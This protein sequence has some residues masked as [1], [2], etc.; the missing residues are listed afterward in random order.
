[1][2]MPVIVPSTTTRDQAIT[3]VIESVALEQT[4]LSH[5]LN[6][7]G[8]KL[9]AVIAMPGVTSAELLDVNKSVQNMVSSI[10]ML[11]TVLQMKLDIFSC[12]ICPNG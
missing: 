4:G 8:E 3:D 2:S 7:E 6:A 10:T 5:I 12:N 11:E 1:M 9:Q